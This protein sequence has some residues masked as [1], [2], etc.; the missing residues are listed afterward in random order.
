MLKL[1]IP[2]L[3]FAF[4]TALLIAGCS[5]DAP[6]VIRVDISTP[7]HNLDP[8]FA[9]DPTARMIIANLFEGL[10]V[11]EPDGQL[12]LGVAADYSVSADGL[13]YTLTLR[14]NAR[15]QDGSAV[16]SQDFVFAFRRIFSPHA[17]SPF[18][19]NFL[20]IANAA[21][22]VEG[23]AA[24][25]ALGI[26]SRGAQ[27][28]VFTLERPDPGFLA[29]LAHTAAMPCN[30][31]A[32]EQ[33]MGRYGLEARYLISNGPFVIGRWN[34][35]Q[36]HLNRNEYFREEKQALS[37]RVTLYI[38]RQDPLRQFLDG[39]SDMVLVP[40]D[41]LDEIAGRS[42]Q[43]VPAQTTTWGLVFNQNTRPWGNPLLRQ[44]LALT[45]D[46]DTHAEDLPANLTATGVFVPPNTLVHGQ[47][48]RAGGGELSPLGLD[49]D[50][51]RRLFGRGLAASGY[52]RLPD[53]AVIV[54]ED[55]EEHLSFMLEAW[56][57][58]LG[59]E[60]AF[61]PVP[62]EELLPRIVTS[63][64]S[65]ILLPFYTTD[66][67]AG[68]LLR[69]FHSGNHFGYNNPRFDHALSAAGLA[70]TPEEAARLYALAEGIL[71]EDTA[72]IPVYFETSYYAL[73]PDLAG[74]EVLP[75]GGGGRFQNAQRG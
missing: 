44:S 54:Q 61:E 16:T 28:V 8:Q 66:G 2:V 56:M 31:A 7:V 4:A 33:S 51:A 1:N 39:R 34:A 72:I 26:S 59:A 20:A 13:I 71:L 23:Y 24:P 50:R 38:G 14:D 22:V 10:M 37:E 47:S 41:R 43:L 18:A 25:T 12:R 42:A 53:F 55:R 11:Q 5:Q 67:K 45:F 65:V 60:A 62:H 21:Q 19:D 29:R 27:T 9:T 17:P 74:V 58:E 70:T 6:S 32:F 35:S 48:F 36:L 40:S 69:S 15:W 57:R 63:D 68:T 64:Y 49:A 73:A 46:Q 30:Q 75:F 52:D 3:V